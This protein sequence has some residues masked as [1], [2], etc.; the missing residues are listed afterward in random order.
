MRSGSYA[1]NGEQR[2]IPNGPFARHARGRDA[3][4]AESLRDAF[5]YL[6]VAPTI[7]RQEDR[8]I[9]V[10]MAVIGTDIMRGVPASLSIG[11]ERVRFIPLAEEKDDLVFR[12]DKRNGR[13]TLDV[14]PAVDTA[15]RLMA[16]LANGSDI[17]LAFAPE[18]TVPGAAEADLQRGI[19]ALAEHAPRIILAGSGLSVATGP[20]GR[21]WNEARVIARGGRVL[22]RQRKMWP[23]G[24]QQGRAV[25]YG[26]P[27]PGD[28]MLMEDVASDSALSVVDLDGF[29]RCVVLICQD[30]QSRPVVDEVVARYQPDWVLIPILDP[31][32]KVPG[33]AHTRALGLSQLSQARHLVGSSLSM[34]HLGPGTGAEPAVGLAVGPAEPNPAGGEPSRAVALV[35]AASGPTPRSAVL[36][37]DYDPSC[38]GKTNIGHS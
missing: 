5:A 21:H 1:E 25:Q 27:D 3:A 6:T 35:T 8:D 10:T 28:Q 30:F 12:P 4:A 18:L 16:A 32:V 7:A 26:F 17:D 24:M 14:Q 9:T 13:P 15:T 37:W 11:R 2:L 33:W 38:W 36:V 22:W 29:G 23:F 19:A 31:G 34:A 20:C